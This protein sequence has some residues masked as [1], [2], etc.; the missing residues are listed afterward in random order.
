MNTFFRNEKWVI[1]LAMIIAVFHTTTQ[2]ADAASNRPLSSVS[3]GETINFG[4]KQWILLDPSKGFII[5]RDFNGS[6]GFE[7]NLGM[8]NTIMI[9]MIIIVS[10]TV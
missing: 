1:A 10:L 7:Y 5:L 6:R 3:A 9:Q 4:G 8:N 2:T